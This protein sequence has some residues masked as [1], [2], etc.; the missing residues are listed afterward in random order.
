MNQTDGTHE[1]VVG[2]GELLRPL[3]QPRAAGVEIAHGLATDIRHGNEHVVAIGVELDVV[4]VG[5]D[6]AEKHLIVVRR[7]GKGCSANVET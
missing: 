1:E 5:M 7:F 6:W 3:P 4:T 2:E